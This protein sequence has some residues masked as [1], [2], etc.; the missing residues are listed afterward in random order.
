[1]ALDFP[2]EPKHLDSVRFILKTLRNGSRFSKQEFVDYLNGTGFDSVDSIE[3]LIHLR[4]MSEDD[5]GILLLSTEK[6]TIDIFREVL[7][8]FLEKDLTLRKI[9]LRIGRERSDAYLRRRNIHQMLLASRLYEDTF[10]ANYWWFKVKEI[11]R[12]FTRTEIQGNVDTGFFGEALTY[13]YEKERLGSSSFI[14]WVSLERNG[15]RHGF[16]IR[17]IKDDDGSGLLIEVKSSGNVPSD[18]NIFLTPNEYDVMISNYQDYVFHLWHSVNE[19]GE[20]EG[21]IIVKAEEMMNKLASLIE[22]GISF[23]DRIKI[24]FSIFYD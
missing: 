24:P 21:P 14:S 22:N 1:M 12:S 5:S 19:D 15:D 7:F 8:Y 20:G 10:Q 3:V 16:D 9:I 4:M 23:T 13:A 6:N 11:N 2:L 18:A 17:S